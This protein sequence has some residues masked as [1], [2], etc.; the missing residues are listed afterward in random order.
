MFSI[1]EMV[2]V[3]VA[4]A[5]M[6]TVAIRE[7]AAKRRTQ[8]MTAEGVNEAVINS[9][10]SDW[11]TNNYTTLIAGGP[12]PVITNPPT[13]NDLFTQGNLKQPHAPGP[14][15]GGSYV[16]SMS[17]GPATCTASAGDCHVTYVMYPSKPLTR[18]GKPDVV[19]A[20]QIAQAGGNAFGY[21]KVQNAGT[22][23]GLNGA[24]TATNPLGSVAA[25]ILATNGPTS[26]G[27]SVYIRRDGALTWTGDQNVNH[28]SLH[29]VHDLDAEGTVSAANVDATGAVA[30]SGAV[31]AGTSVTAGTTVV[32]GAIGWPRTAC[33]KVNAMTGASDNSGLMLS[34]QNLSGVLQ[35]MPIGGPKLWYGY[36]AIPSGGGTYVP[37][38]VCP[39]GGT[40]GIVVTGQSTYTDPTA[41][42]NYPTTGTGPWT[43]YITD[44]NGTVIAGS[45]VANT[46]CAY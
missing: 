20:A 12:V 35:W 5:L 38:P 28:V 23:T 31:A 41:A 8:V 14:F 43:V 6:T 22:I 19:G 39:A 44:G 13:I 4:A 30:A 36:T 24:W 3:L 11:V 32:P 26:D 10:L 18:G 33:P 2:V 16:I 17:V 37:G 15:W 40:P 34:C 1:V 7:D 42:I 45:A 9:A 21:S 27:N 29:N 25:A 46:F